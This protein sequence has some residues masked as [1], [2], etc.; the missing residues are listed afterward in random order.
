MK[1][2]LAILGAC[3]TAP[4]FGAGIIAPM[5]QRGLPAQFT[6]TPIQI[7]GLVDD[8]WAK[9]QADPLL[10]PYNN[11]MTGPPVGDCPIKANVRALWDGALLYVLVSVE[12]R[13][14]DTRAELSFNK[15]GV[16]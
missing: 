12:D 7:D 2:G 8:A 10:L 16:E 4:V 14:V 6:P 13:S 15:D 9:A 5:T 11:E 3:V 1:K